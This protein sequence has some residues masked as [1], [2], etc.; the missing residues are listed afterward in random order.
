M[1]L[2]RIQSGKTRSFIGIIAGAF[3]A[4]VDFAIVLTKGTSALSEQTI[5]RINSDFRDA[6]ED[7]GVLVFDIMH[8]PVNLTRYH[9]NQKWI[10]V[11]KKE[12]NNLKRIFD[13]LNQKYPNLKSKRVLIVDDEADYASLTYRK[14]PDTEEIEPGKIARWVDDLR[15]ASAATH[16]L[17]V[18][19]TPYSVFLQPSDAEDTPLF[20]PVRPAFTE[21]LPTHDSYVGGDFF[22]GESGDESS[23]ASFV[24]EPVPLS[25]RDTLKKEDRRSFKIEEA[26]TARQISTLRRAIVNF[27]LGGCIRRWQQE[28]NSQRRERYSFVVHT[29]QGRGAHSWQERVVRRIVEQLI[30]AAAS[31]TPQFKALIS[32]AFTD[33]SRSLRLLTE[34]YPE[35]QEAQ[36]LVRAALRDEHLVVTV[37]NSEHKV[38]DHLDDEGQLRLSAP[39]NVFIGGQILDRGIT[40]RNLIGFYYGRNPQQFQQD[41]VLQHARLYGARKR[42]DLAVTRFY[43]TSHIHGVMRKV[44]DFDT[45][46]RQAIERGDQL[47]GVYFLRRDDSGRLIP[48]SPNKILISDIVTLR[49]HHR[50]LPIGF[51]TGFKSYIG[52]RVSDLDN[53]IRGSLR[54]CTDPDSPALIDVAVAEAILR[55]VAETLEF[56][57]PDFQWDFESHIAA[58]HHMA[59]VSGTAET[60]G[61]VWLLV[62]E[63]RDLA[64]FR[65]DEER[66]SDAPDSYQEIRLARQI[67]IDAPALTLIR[68]DGREEKGWRGVPFWWPIITPSKLTKTTIFA[69]KTRSGE[70]NR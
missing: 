50:L 54:D 2:G 63:G 6:I 5:K 57:D 60:R 34:T 64:R 53:L 21:L 26:L 70:A 46:L 36:E 10:I 51:Q 1:L 20:H 47:N 25:E 37:V 45:A 22:F 13:A 40:I 41:T 69:S 12:K 43:T 56:E 32:D 33:L 28:R 31:A 15:H 27:I 29:E 11:A 4:G 23:T 35:L 44:H 24:Y 30:E 16:F 39:L 65:D 52:R 67:A 49:A 59:S 61:K 9:L 58:V 38:K 3:D 55:G 48:C 66:Y 18:T 19:A 62:K 68:E 42:N 17:Q 8:L 7:E 14:N